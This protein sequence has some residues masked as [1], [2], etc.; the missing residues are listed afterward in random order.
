VGQ[1]LRLLVLNEPDERAWDLVAERLA[2][3]SVR[4]S[5]RSSDPIEIAEPMVFDHRSDFRKDPDE[6]SDENELPH[7]YSDDI[8]DDGDYRAKGSRQP[9]LRKGRAEEDRVTGLGPG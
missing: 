1:H 5:I 9:A 8:P 3:T 6:V 4:M 2:A 7:C